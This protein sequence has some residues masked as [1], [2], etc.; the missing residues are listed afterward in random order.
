[1]LFETEICSGT[2]RFF[3]TDGRNE[4][5]QIRTFN[6]FLERERASSPGNTQEKF[7]LEFFVS[8]A[9]ITPLGKGGF[10][11]LPLLNLRGA[12]RPR[13]ARF[14]VDEPPGNVLGR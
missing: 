4:E 9:D 8:P 11:S 6:T 12:G 7:I 3:F 1:M 2:N 14:K 10:S 13:A 5:N